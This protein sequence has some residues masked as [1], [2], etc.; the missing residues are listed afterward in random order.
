MIAKMRLKL[1]YSWGTY[2]CGGHLEV[3]LNEVAEALSNRGAF[4][5]VRMNERKLR[6]LKL[7]GRSYGLMA[8]THEVIEIPLYSGPVKND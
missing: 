6:E 7:L 5:R 8:S 1:A 4:E 3:D 2:D